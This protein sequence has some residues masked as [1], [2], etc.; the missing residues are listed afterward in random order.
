[1]RYNT[2]LRQ[3]FQRILTEAFNGV[4][5]DFDVDL[6][7]STLGR[8]LMRIP[9]NPGDLAARPD[10]KAL[11][12]RLVQAMRR[13]EDELHDALVQRHGEESGKRLFARYERAF[14]AGYRD[15]F[16][17]QDA[18]A[19]VEKIESLNPQSDLGMNL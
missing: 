9:N 3:R 7:A 2:E 6:S 13:W 12:Q 8:I 1:E 16:S 5:S 14:P 19:D 17:V 18:L 10:L 11:E 15:E 4:S